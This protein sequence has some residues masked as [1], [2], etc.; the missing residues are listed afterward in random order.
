MN[1]NQLPKKK[2]LLTLLELYKS[3]TR[4]ILIHCNGGA[5]RTGEAAA[6]WVLDQQN[7]RKKDALN[8]LAFKYGHIKLKTPKKRKFIKM[9]QGREWAE[10]IYK[11]P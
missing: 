1:A 9:W 8:Q 5:D 10:N 11:S 2:N 6:L 7:R 3:A 4:P